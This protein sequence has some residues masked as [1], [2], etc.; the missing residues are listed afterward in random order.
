MSVIF[1][2]IVALLTQIHVFS[3]PAPTQRL[4]SLE[5]RENPKGLC[6]V[7]PLSWAEKQI[8]VF[9]GHKK[10]SVQIVVWYLLF[11]YEEL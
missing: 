1:R 4:F 8:L 5:T 10:G 7:S 3:F 11:I 2:V 6:E 9:P